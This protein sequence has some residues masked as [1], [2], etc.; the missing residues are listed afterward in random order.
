MNNSN[1]EIKDFYEA[2]L[3]LSQHPICGELLAQK[4]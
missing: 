1:S 2:I 4:Q 3:L